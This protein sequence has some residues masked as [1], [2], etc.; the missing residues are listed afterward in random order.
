M[1]RF[2]RLASVL[3]AAAMTASMSGCGSKKAE[4]I[5]DYGNGAT[6]A[7]TESLEGSSE[8]AS[9]EGSSL[10]IQNEEYQF[11]DEFNVGSVK[12]SID[13]TSE[14][15]TEYAFPSFSAEKVSETNFNAE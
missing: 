13:V 10:T 2:K 11:Q 12:V 3:I 1:I 4:I 15:L 9:E 5:E 8:E 14:P 7:E 6:I